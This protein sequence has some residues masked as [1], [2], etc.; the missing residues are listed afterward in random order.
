MKILSTLFLFI[1]VLISNVSAQ[2]GWVQQTS[3]TTQVLLGVSFADA[4]TGYAC[5]LSGMILKTTNAGTNWVSLP[6]VTGNFLRSIHFVNPANFGYAAGENGIVLKTTTGGMNWTP[7][8]NAGSHTIVHIDFKDANT[9]IVVGLEGT[10][11]TTTN[12]GTNWISRKSGVNVELTGVYMVTPDN[13]YAV[14]FNGTIIRTTNGGANWTMQSSGLTSELRA[15]YFV[16]DN[17]GFVVGYNGRILKTTNAGE[18]WFSLTPGVT[19]NLFS[20]YCVDENIVYASGTGIILK[21]TN[22]GANWQNQN[23]TVTSDLYSIAFSS[24]TLGLAVGQQGVILKTTTGGVGINQISN[25]VPERFILHQ[26]YPNPFNP[27]TK[28]KFEI[29]SGSKNIKLAV[30]DINGREVSQLFSGILNAGIYETK[31]GGI[32]ASSGVYFYSLYINESLMDTKK[33]LFIK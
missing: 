15:V 1:L 27:V 26:N 9:G 33:M 11:M 28:I 3:G 16:N 23:V 14:G 29:P 13:I 20:I 17:T 25:Q 10:I 12:G 2:T 21:T 18:N 30:F 19:N 7:T 5:G 22:G 4:N 24:A 6:A 32:N 31:W 8:G